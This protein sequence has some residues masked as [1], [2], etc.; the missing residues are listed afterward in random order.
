MK[1]VKFENNV[2]KVKSTLDAVIIKSLY[3]IAGEILARTVHTTPVKSSQLRNSWTYA[4]DEDKKVA[5][6]GSP[7]ENAI[8]NELGTGEF[9][10]NGDGR[11]GGWFYEDENGEWHHTYGKPPRRTLYRAALNSKPVAEGI[12]KN[13]LKELNKK[14]PRTPESLLANVIKKAI[15]VGK[16][17][18]KEI[19][20]R[21]E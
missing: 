6:I 7:L 13:N 10:L 14:N 9:A 4:V 12:L 3:E 17:V 15:E 1:N 16:V 20:E 5:Y 2:E 18:V 8:W 21:V 19:S 11:K